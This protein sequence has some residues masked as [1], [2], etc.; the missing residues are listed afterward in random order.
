MRFT[1]VFAAAALAAPLALAAPTSATSGP[2][3]PATIDLDS[4]LTLN[5]H[6]A[7]ALWQVKGKY[8]DISEE[9]AKTAALGYLEAIGVQT[10]GGASNNTDLATRDIEKRCCSGCD[11]GNCIIAIFLLGFCCIGS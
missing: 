9:D 3:T 7:T 2:A 8:P 10:T 11:Q 6:Y 4:D 1:Q 5:P